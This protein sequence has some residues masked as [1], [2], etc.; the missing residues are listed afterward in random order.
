MAMSGGGEARFQP[1]PSAVLELTVVFE[2]LRAFFK[3]GE[4][5]GFDDSDSDEG[6][7]SAESGD[8]DE[9]DEGEDEDPEEDDDGELDSEEEEAENGV[10][11]DAAQVAVDDPPP[12]K[13]KTQCSAALPEHIWRALRAAHKEVPVHRRGH[14][15]KAALIAGAPRPPAPA[16]D[17]QPPPKH[18]RVTFIYTVLQLAVCSTFFQYVFCVGGRV[19]KRARAELL[20]QNYTQ[21]KVVKPKHRGP[22]PNTT[23]ITSFLTT[24]FETHGLSLCHCH[25]KP[26]AQQT[27]W[28]F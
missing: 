25:Y 24:F 12:C 9:D 13:C 19:M 6:N 18:A 7:T 2:N 22:K 4:A 3:Y 14:L 17:G 10:D 26:L 1:D 28:V 11:G 27:H 21:A 23:R 16:V 8:E 5:R 20:A 15:V